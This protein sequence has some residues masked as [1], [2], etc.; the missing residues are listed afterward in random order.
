[1][2]FLQ[3]PWLI[4]RRHVRDEDLLGP[5]VVGERCRARLPLVRNGMDRVAT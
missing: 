1:L 4:I 5:G 3:I 2:P